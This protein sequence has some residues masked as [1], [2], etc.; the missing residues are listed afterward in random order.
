MVSTDNEMNNLGA[1]T[2]TDPETEVSGLVWEGDPGATQLHND[3][4]MSLLPLNNFAGIPGIADENS[5]HRTDRAQIPKHTIHRTSIRM[6]HGGWEAFPVH[7]QEGEA[8]NSRWGPPGGNSMHLL[9]RDPIPNPSH[10]GRSEVV[11]SDVTLSETNE[12]TE[13]CVGI[14]QVRYCV[15]NLHQAY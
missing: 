11:G 6:I 1:S 4:A 7:E 10:V 13:T 12:S 14:G 5:L 3:S 15:L 2:S 8:S 9:L